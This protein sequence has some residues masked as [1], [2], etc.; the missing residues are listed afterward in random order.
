MNGAG[1]SS[2]GGQ[3][4]RQKGLDWFNPDTYTRQLMEALGMGLAE[5]NGEAWQEGVR[6]LED[7]LA[8]G[9]HYAFETTLGAT[10]I[11]SKL[12]TAA[13]SHDVMIWFCGLAS[14]EKHLERVKLRV[15]HGGHDIPE[16]KIR[17]RFQTSRV[18]LVELLPF[19][20]RL[21]VYDNSADAEPN[22]PIPD[23]RLILQV[24]AQKVLVPVDDAAMIATPDWA[25]PIVQAALDA[26]PSRAP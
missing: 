22:G 17:E 11:P 24:N 2:I 3:I 16:D 8:N 7:A 25:K 6:R 5:A 4:I 21:Q 10:T 18:N 19:I 14:P 23:P 13:A 15:A 9:H 1:K 20:A 26:D 12:K